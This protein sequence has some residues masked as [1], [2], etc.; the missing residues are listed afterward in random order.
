MVGSGLVA[1]RTSRRCWW[2]W[3][4]RYRV[5]N[6]LKKEVW[7]APKDIEVVLPEQMSWPFW[8]FEILSSW[9]GKEVS[10]KRSWTLAFMGF[11]HGECPHDWQEGSSARRKE[12]RS[13]GIFQLPWSHC[14]WMPSVACQ[15]L[16]PCSCSSR[17]LSRCRVL[18]LPIM[19]GLRSIDRSLGRYIPRFVVGWVERVGGKE[20]SVLWKR[21]FRFNFPKNISWW[22][23][24]AL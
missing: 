3:A 17:I 21:T 11:E 13:I 16:L 12:K 22:A 2:H 18:P 6:A 23:A 10:A 7:Y 20:L 1:F 5:S 8:R 15:E 24:R 9:S 4:H 14:C 19:K